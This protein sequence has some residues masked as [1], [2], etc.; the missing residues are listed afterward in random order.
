M[1]LTIREISDMINSNLPKIVAEIYFENRCVL[2]QDVYKYDL[3][4][5][6]F[7]ICDMETFT[8]TFK[9]NN[10]YFGHFPALVPGKAFTNF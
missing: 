10:K 8:Q 6:L 1:K 5:M 2:S 9:L 4:K 7:K 3:K